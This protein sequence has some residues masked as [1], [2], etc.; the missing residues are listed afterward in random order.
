MAIF[1]LCPCR[2]PSA[3]TISLT[4]SPTPLHRPSL[5]LPFLAQRPDPRDTKKEIRT[6]KIHFRICKMETGRFEPLRRACLAVLSQSAPPF[7]KFQNRPPAAWV[8]PP[9]WIE[10]E[11]APLIE[12]LK[13][14]TQHFF[15]HPCFHIFTS[16][17]WRL[18]SQASSARSHCTPAP[19]AHPTLPPP[20]FPVT[21]KPPHTRNSGDQAFV[22][23][24]KAA[25]PMR[26]R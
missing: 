3:Q 8:W 26:Y 21:S 17:P 7:V 22:L 25:H 13:H 11:T 12:P 5:F 10:P 16:C 4:W 2:A 20:P 14:S 18:F 19:V 15:C 1:G 23:L 6:C 9:G 24:E